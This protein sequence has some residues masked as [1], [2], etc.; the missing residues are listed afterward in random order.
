MN[1]LTLV[2]R[3]FFS[4]YF[5]ATQSGDPVKKVLESQCWHAW[6]KGKLKVVVRGDLRGEGLSQTMD[7]TEGHRD[8]LGNP[9]GQRRKA[10]PK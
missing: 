1:S 6:G 9:Q 5:F 10:E 3:A 4:H 7:I 8:I 2:N